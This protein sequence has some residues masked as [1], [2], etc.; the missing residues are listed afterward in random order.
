MT[1]QRYRELRESAAARYKPEQ[2]K[3]LLVAEAPP[4]SLERYFYFPEVSVH[5]PL[6]RYVAKELLGIGATRW[7]KPDL[8]ARLQERGVFLIDLCL[9]PV[10][11]KRTLGACVP[12]LI[13]RISALTPEHVILIKVTVYDAAY[14]RLQSAAL[15]VVNERIPFP[16]TG[17]Q[18][19]FEEAFRRALAAMRYSDQS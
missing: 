1:F 8:L 7:N 3:L 11:D 6:F 14:V 16:S 19:R 15:P 18:R 12:D 9:D 5:D 13:D 10:P 4:D 17:Q 2:V